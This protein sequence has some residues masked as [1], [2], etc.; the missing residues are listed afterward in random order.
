M[1]NKITYAFFGFVAGLLL[2]AFAGLGEMRYIKKSQRSF[3]L[4]ILTIGGS[5]VGAVIGSSIGF[6]Y[7]W[8][9]IY[10]K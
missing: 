7:G 1:T 3:S 6:K 8:E 5:L 9:S 2:G 4:P 10:E